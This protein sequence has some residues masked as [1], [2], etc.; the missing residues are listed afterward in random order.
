M[1]RV[2]VGVAFGV[3]TASTRRG[4]LPWLGGLFGAKS[5]TTPDPNGGGASWRS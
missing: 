2:A 4:Y 5:P 3:T 1:S